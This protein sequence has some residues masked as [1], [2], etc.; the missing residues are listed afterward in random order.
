MKMIGKSTTLASSSS[1]PTARMTPVRLVMWNSKPQSPEH[2][3]NTRIDQ[4]LLGITDLDINEW[5]GGAA[6]SFG[7]RRKP[8]FVI[9]TK[10][11]IQKISLL[12]NPLDP[13]F[14]RGDDF[15][16]DR[17]YSRIPAFAKK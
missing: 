7:S 6:L 10:V 12:K 11:G 2:I 4:V 3:I 8:V 13:G 9:P 16:R 5:V 14:H 15:L 17:Q 1:I